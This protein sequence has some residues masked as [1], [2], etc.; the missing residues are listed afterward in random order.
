MLLV[1]RFFVAGSVLTSSSACEQL[2]L[3]RCALLSASLLAA[4][5]AGCTI[6]E[7]GGPPAPSPAESHA[8]VMRLLPERTSDR[9]GWATDIYAAFAAL[10]LVPNADNVCA[11]I[12]VTEQESSFKA[13]PTVPGLGKIAWKEID[14]RAGRLGIPPI[15]VRTALRIASP[16]GRSYSERIDKAR[17]EQELS[18]VFEDLI[19][20]VPMGKRLFGSWNPV[21]TGGPMQVS[22]AYAQ[23]HAQ[24]RDYPYPVKESI[25]GEVFTR[26]GGMYFGIAHLLDYP[27]A[28]DRQLYRFADFNAGHYA[29]RNAAFQNAAGIASGKE[30]VLD[31]D[32]IDHSA[33][34]S[35]APGSTER[36]VRSLGARLGMSDAEI[37]RDL[38][39]GGSKDFE[40]TVVYR[41]VFELAQ[42][43]RKAA[44]PRA[45]V[46]KIRLRSPKI[47]RNLT[48]SWFADR[49]ESRYRRCLTRDEPARGGTLD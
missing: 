11:V 37:R 45:V 36:A 16:D 2:R 42:Q 23:A 48:T 10:E 46:P 31:G 12:A 32:L 34:A 18:E 4:A 24:A 27:A 29:S 6:T 49:V 1:A 30:L 9:V 47:T 28:Y 38:E 17:T 40:R 39:K 44:L 21:R 41:R 26:H 22:I 7:Q 5:L 33:G 8:L 35:G 20:L 19:G 13:A 3:R 15:V 43:R 14:E 25:R